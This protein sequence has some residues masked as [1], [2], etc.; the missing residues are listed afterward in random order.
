M[1]MPSRSFIELGV[2]PDAPDASKLYAEA[3][4][5]KMTRIEPRNA[6]GEDKA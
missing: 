1:H 4:L 5:P 2:L 3:F 6:G